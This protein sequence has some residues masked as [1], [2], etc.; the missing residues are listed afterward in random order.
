VRKNR[1]AVLVPLDETPEAS[2]IEPETAEPVFDREWAEAIKEHALAE[3]AA[4]YQK[5]GKSTWYDVLIRL[6]PG[7]DNPVTQAE[8]A[9]ALQITANQARVEYHR[10]RERIEAAVR[11]QVTTTVSHPGDVDEELHH[12]KEYLAG[13]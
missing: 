1:R 10:F 3:V 8:T 5:R 12:L 11:R 7:A 4:W 6:L 13:H 9:T 2:L